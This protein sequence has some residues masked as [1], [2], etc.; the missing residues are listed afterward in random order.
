MQFRSLSFL[1]LLAV[2]VAS[3]P[4]PQPR[5]E[6][7]GDSGGVVGAAIDLAGA[8]VDGAA[9]VASDAADGTVYSLYIDGDDGA[10]DAVGGAVYI[11]G[12]V[13]DAVGNVDDPL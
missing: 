5:V 12:V 1:A 7:D 11:G 3:S 2:L 13:D 10:E 9:V 6:V 4:V 8:A